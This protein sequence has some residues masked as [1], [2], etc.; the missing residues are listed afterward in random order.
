MKR[1]SLILWILAGG[2]AM[3]AVEVRYLHRDISSEHWQGWIPVLY[4][5]IAAIAAGWAAFTGAIGKLLPALFAVG[6]LAGL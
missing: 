5:A 1:D 4:G 3:T 6:V 2:F